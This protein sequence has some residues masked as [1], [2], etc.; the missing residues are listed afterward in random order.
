MLNFRQR[1]AALMLDQLCR[2][3]DKT[4]KESLSFTS[5][6][7]SGIY[8]WILEHLNKDD[9]WLREKV[10]AMGCYGGETHNC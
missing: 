1:Y 6:G 7:L 4:I 3:S 9:L 5:S 2:P 10:F 8:S